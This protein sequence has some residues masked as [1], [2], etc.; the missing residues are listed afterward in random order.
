LSEKG[1]VCMSQKFD[2]LKR[3]LKNVD[4]QKA[5]QLMKDIKKAR[6]DGKIDEY[7]KKELI[8]QVKVLAKDIDFGGIMKNIGSFFKK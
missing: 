8:T 3:S 4:K 2:E 1:G 7:E 5:G 6:Q